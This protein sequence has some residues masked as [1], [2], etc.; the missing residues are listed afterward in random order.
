MA[1]SG[2]PRVPDGRAAGQEQGKT[3]DDQEIYD[4]QQQ[5]IKAQLRNSYQHSGLLISSWANQ[6]AAKFLSAAT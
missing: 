4:T 3:G 1:G 2:D 5:N 6:R